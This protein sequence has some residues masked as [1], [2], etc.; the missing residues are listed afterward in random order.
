ML[1]SFSMGVEGSKFTVLFP[2]LLFRRLS[3]DVH[4]LMFITILSAWV[5]YMEINY[6]PLPHA[7][8]HYL[9]HLASGMLNT[10]LIMILNACRSK[11]NCFVMKLMRVAYTFLLSSIWCSLSH[12]RNYFNVAVVDLILV[13]G[14]QVATKV[15]QAHLFLIAAFSF[16]RSNI[17]SFPHHSYSFGIILFIFSHLL[18]LLSRT[19][20]WL[21]WVLRKTYLVARWLF[22]IRRKWQWRVA[23]A[24]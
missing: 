20:W 9:S 8:S 3:S 23:K 7:P 15:C 14:V 17:W 19:V 2:C 12:N 13:V 10:T 24:L 18:C 11:L 5:I 6:S 22:S 1:V 16:A 4:F 21:S